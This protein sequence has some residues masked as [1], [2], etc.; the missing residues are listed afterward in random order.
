MNSNLQRRNS[1]RRVGRSL[2]LAS[3]DLG[4]LDAFDLILSALDFFEGFTADL[5]LGEEFRL[6][7]CLKSEAIRVSASSCY[8][9]LISNELATHKTTST[10]RSFPKEMTP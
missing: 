6:K 4:L 9:Y 5:L 3:S 2:L 7:D 10:S 1:D 8:Y